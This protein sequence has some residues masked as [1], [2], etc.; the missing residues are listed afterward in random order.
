MLAKGNCIVSSRIISLYKHLYLTSFTNRP[1]V[2]EVSSSEYA[3]DSS[4]SSSS[5]SGSP[6]QY[7]GGSPSLPSSEGR[8]RTGVRP[9]SFTEGGN[10]EDLRP[11]SNTEGGS[12][13]GSTSS[14]F[15]IESLLNK[16]RPPGGYQQRYAATFSAVTDQEMVSSTPQVSSQGTPLSTSFQNSV[17]LDNKDNVSDSI[18]ASPARSAE[19][20][21][22]IRLLE[23]SLA[24]S[25][26]MSAEVSNKLLAEQ[27]HNLQRMQMS[28]EDRA[29]EVQRQV[30][31]V[32]MGFHPDDIPD[33]R[34]PW[35]SPHDQTVSISDSDMWHLAKF[36]PWHP[37]LRNRMPEGRHYLLRNVPPGTLT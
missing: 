29:R 25:K 7:G 27:E 33:S 20:A 36:S 1:Q 3:S 11:P 37:V 17:V 12:Q 31:S 32:G 6:I 26:T 19:V 22:A 2:E 9:P 14:A 18:P 30:G 15:D 28:A 34:I 4:S 8:D 35:V 24:K 13:G 5:S 23:E 16:F 21:K 10:P